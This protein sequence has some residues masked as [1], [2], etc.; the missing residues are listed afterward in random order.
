VQIL[1]AYAEDLVVEDAAVRIKAIKLLGAV[2][3]VRAR[4][5]LELS[6]PI[7]FFAEPG[8]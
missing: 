5:F 2:F 7:C 1:P 6:L 4:I 3:S 8:E